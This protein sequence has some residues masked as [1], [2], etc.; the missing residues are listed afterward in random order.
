VGAQK[1]AQGYLA[2]ILDD[3]LTSRGDRTGSVSEVL[4]N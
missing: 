4:G 1:L 3:P 2:L